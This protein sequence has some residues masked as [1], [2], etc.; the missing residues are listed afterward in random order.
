MIGLETQLTVTIAAYGTGGRDKFS[1]TRATLFSCYGFYRCRP[2]APES[3]LL[4][5]PPSPLFNVQS[6]DGSPSLAAN[7]VPSCAV[8]RGVARRAKGF[9][10]INAP[11]C[12]AA[13]LR[14]KPRGVL[15]FI[16]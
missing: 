10:R 12:A 5:S 11:G 3:D 8:L 14:G 1:T 16:C 13:A 2:V 9:P 6:V 4:A 15:Q 7:V